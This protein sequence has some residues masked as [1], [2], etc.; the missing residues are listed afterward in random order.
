[1]AILHQV[2]VKETCLKPQNANRRENKTKRKQ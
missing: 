2:L 1:M